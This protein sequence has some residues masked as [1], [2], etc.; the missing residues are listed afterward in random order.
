M[1]SRS[2]FTLVELLAVIGIIGILMML[3]SPQIGQA[4]AR[5]R[6]TA[7]RNNMSLLLKA[8]FAFAADHDGLMASAWS[9]GSQATNTWQMCFIGQ[10]LFPTGITVSTEWP[11]GKDGTLL[12]YMGSREAVRRLSRCPGLP[13]GA[14]RSGTGS[15]GYFD[16]AVFEIF[17]GAKQSRMPTRAQVDLGRGLEDVPCPWLVE[18]DPAE[19]LNAGYIQPFH[20]STDRLGAW[21][22]GRG[23]I[24]TPEGAVVAIGPARRIS[25]VFKN[26]RSQD[27]RA[28]APSSTEIRLSNAAVAAPD[29]WGWWNRQ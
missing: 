15:N 19:F 27:W 7:C 20:K 21:H 5:A 8:S 3:I 13:S 6:E 4:I 12:N 17:A 29:G 18:E 1:R 10:E 11:Q 16:Y 28:R 23:N 24:G 14:L 2:G 9:R 22:R 25:N 26:P